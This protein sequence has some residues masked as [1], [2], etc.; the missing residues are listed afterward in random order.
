MK[1]WKRM[2]AALLVLVVCA[3][4]M[5][6]MAVGTDLTCTVMDGGM[7]HSIALKED[8]TV[9]TWGANQQMQLGRAEQDVQV[10]SP[11]QLE[12]LEGIVAVAAGYDFSAALGFDGTV[13]T[14]G[15]G[16]QSKP[17]AVSGLSGVV[18]ISAGQT[19]LLALDR[20]GE[21]WQW[22]LG[23]AP[24]KVSGLKNI[25]AV[26]AGGSHYLALTFS[27]DVYAWG[28]NWSGQLGTG[29]TSDSATPKKLDLFNIVD[30]AAGY[31]HSLAVG[32]DGTVY[33]WG[34]NT[35]GQLGNGTT[36]DSAEPVEVKT[37][38][39]AVQVSAGNED[40]MAL[41]K[42]GKIYTWGYGEYGQLGREG[43]S[44]TQ[45]TPR[46]LGSTVRNAAQIASGVYH[47][48][49]VTEDGTL[50]AW[51]RNRDYQL[52]T[53]KNEN[54]STPQRVMSKNASGDIYETAVLNGAS[55]WASAELASLYDTGLVPPLLWQSYRGNVT[56]AEFAHLLV[57]L[58]EEIKGSS[59]SSTNRTDFS[60]ID[61]HLLREDILK[62]A[63]LKLINGTSETTFSP[64]A[65]LTRQEAAK[66]LC[67]FL[68]KVADAKIP[69]KAGT[70]TYYSDASQIAEWAAPYVSYAY[71]ENIMQGSDFKFAPLT[72]LTREQSLLIVARLVERYEWG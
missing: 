20:N 71:K 8:G 50:Y 26:D 14:W 49:Y 42:D 4:P 30:I 68:T 53:K 9:Y 22:T 27:G 5:S 64:D 48:M 43:A 24:A 39:K 38:Q 28:S 63:N 2:A 45:S 33:A 67:T 32:F 62:A 46:E 55:P 41:T 11:E 66:M 56:R 52:G 16:Q 12:G 57:S 17:T 40:S 69:E 60:D 51:G 29:N 21:V 10:Q 44:I 37:V 36:R 23:A 61:D 54:A 6:A 3:A 35:Y 19:S 65:A 34:S 13:Y 1:V 58:Y 15:G 72:P 25:A 59:L 47:N 70:L 7:S 31:S 18:A